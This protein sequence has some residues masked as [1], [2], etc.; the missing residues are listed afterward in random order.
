M[1]YDYI[2]TTFVNFKDNQHL[3]DIVG[4]IDFEWRKN[5]ENRTW[6]EKNRKSRS[7]KYVFFVFVCYC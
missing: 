5:N 3:L 1:K 2:F 7:W 4:E 6:R